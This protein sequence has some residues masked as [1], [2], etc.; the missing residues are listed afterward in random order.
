LTSYS[1]SP[2]EEMSIALGKDT[3][4]DGVDIDGYPLKITLNKP[5]FA[6]F[7]TMSKLE[8]A[9]SDPAFIESTKDCLFRG[10]N[11]PRFPESATGRAPETIYAT[12]VNEIRWAK[13]EHPTAKIDHH[14]IV[15]PDWGTVF[16]GE[17]LITST[18]RRVTLLR[19]KLGSPT[20][21]DFAASEYETN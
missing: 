3:V 9:G 4:I 2:R 21:G 1:G 7:D 12:V 14:A 6:Q 8:A 5:T 18:S 17:I 19:A 13:K 16:F 10:P 20:G 15:I 11:A